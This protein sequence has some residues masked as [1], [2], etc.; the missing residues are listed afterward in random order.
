MC[1]KLD[2][3]SIKDLFDPAI[4]INKFFKRLTTQINGR[5]AS[6]EHCYVFFKDFFKS[7]N[8][9]LDAAALNLAFYLASWG[10]YRGSSFLLQHDYKIHKDLIENIIDKEKISDD[11]IKYLLNDK[12]YNK[13]NWNTIYNLI[14]NYGAKIELCNDKENNDC[15][16][17]DNECKCDNNENCGMIVKA[18]SKY[19]KKYADKLPS[20]TLVTKI[21]MGIFGCIP[22]Y[23]RYFKKGVAIYNKFCVKDKDKIG[24]LNPK[25]YE[26]LWNFYENKIKI[27]NNIKTSLKCSEYK[28]NKKYKYPPMKLVDSYFWQI[29]YDADM[30]KVKCDNNKIYLCTLQKGSNGNIENVLYVYTKT[31]N[32]YIIKLNSDYK[33]PQKIEIEEGIT[34]KPEE[35]N[36]K[37][38]TAKEKLEKN[39]YDSNKEQS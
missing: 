19:A 17:C 16:N 27:K 20:D 35:L 26:S 22:A 6:W 10:M 12:D 29:G 24:G 1:K 38:E 3:N 4:Q 28:N 7:E 32:I 2:K 34:L 9:D 37:I 8:K 25:G 30:G 23:D 11:K 18:Y 39:I 13:E 5:Y 21:L 36:A 14:K 15:D 33:L 31:N